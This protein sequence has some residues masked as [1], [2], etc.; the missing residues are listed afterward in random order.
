VFVELQPDEMAK[1]EELLAWIDVRET[2]LPEGDA[3]IV[4]LCVLIWFAKL[5][6]IVEVASLP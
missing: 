2:V 5:A 6:A 4:E 1:L 3:V